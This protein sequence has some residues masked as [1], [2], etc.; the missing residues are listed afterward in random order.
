MSDLA[1]RRAA[2]RRAVGPARA[3]PLI[4]LA[5]ELTRCYVNAG[6]GR[7]DAQPF[8]D[9]AAGVTEEAYG[10]FGAGDVM[11][12]QVQAMRGW[13]RGT[14]HIAHGSP[15]DDRTAGIADLE[16]GLRSPHL[17]PAQQTIYRITL[18]Q[19]YLAEVTNLLRSPEMT[20]M[21]LNGG[22]PDRAI[23]DVDRAIACFQQLL[24]APALGQEVY[25]MA[26]IQMR[27][28][29]AMRE[30]V[31]AV[32]DP[33]P[34][35]RMNKIMNASAALQEIHREQSE[36]AKL[37]PDAPSRSFYFAETIVDRHPLDRPTMLVE[38]DDSTPPVDRAAPAPVSEPADV[39]ELKR[40]LRRRTAAGGDLMEALEALLAPAAEPPAPLIDEMIALATTIVDSGEANHTDDLL[41]AA[42]LAVRGTR[43]GG[44][45]LDLQ[46][47]AEALIRSASGRRFVPPDVARVMR[48]IAA[49]IDTVR[50]GR[51]L[52]A[53]LTEMIS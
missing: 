47:A 33:S 15:A 42:G 27:V 39:P 22:L 7:P 8:L 36:R 46:D 45:D 14:R 35:E 44:D 6:P 21:L 51:R 18:G 53:R 23:N 52:T 40:R 13:I 38:V 5:Q 34:V 41:L 9:E 28:A 10:L 17:P 20:S 24:E 29:E 3:K 16:E 2:V 1:S 49:M 37:G 12:P 11:R 43:A 30:M 31:R 26:R 48:R 4:E 50:P 19:L 25:D 32:D